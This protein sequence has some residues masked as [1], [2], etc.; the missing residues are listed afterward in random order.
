MSEFD[1]RT[2]I[3]DPRTGKLQ[4]VQTYRMI[5][6]R[7]AGTIYERPEHS[8]SWFY[9]DGSPIPMESLP[10]RFRPQKKEEPKAEQAAKK[11]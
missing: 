3:F 10:E 9:P 7:T 2:H 6:D 8:G 4:T 11:A 1:K 5:V